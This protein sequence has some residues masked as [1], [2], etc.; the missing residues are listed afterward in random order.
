MHA[1]NGGERAQDGISPRHVTLGLVDR[2]REFNFYPKCNAKPFKSFKQ[3]SKS[4][5]DLC[6][7]KDHSG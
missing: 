4:R 3:R 1:L 6:F 7:Q 2:D 5:F